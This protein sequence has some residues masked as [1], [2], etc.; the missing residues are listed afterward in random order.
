MIYLYSG[1]P[2]SGKSLH[3]AEVIFFKLRARHPVLANFDVN[4]Q[5][6][7]GRGRRKIAD[8]RYFSNED[9]SPGGLMDYSAAYF[10]NHRFREGQILLVIDE[11]QLLFNSRE[12]DAKGRAAWLSF[13]SQHRKY[14]YD[15]ILVA[16]FDR[17]LDRQIRSLIEYEYIHRKV[18][19][20]GVWGKIFSV[21]FLG[22]L[23]VSVK[24]WYPLRERIG[25]D[26]FVCK[27]KFFR[28]YDT[29]K[30]FGEDEQISP[31]PAR[32]PAKEKNE[33]NDRNKLLQDLV[34]VLE[35]FR[36]QKEAAEQHFLCNN[37]VAA[38]AGKKSSRFKDLLFRPISLFANN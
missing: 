18:S 34:T 27:P 14:G 20:F 8:F 30:H 29:Y 22:K 28:L 23:F 4:T 5:F 35:I 38:P 32:K 21:F 17:M 31:K 2:G 10:K 7:M 9:L 6:V 15:V 12:W 16:Q 24:M 1:T 33:E 26:W 36:Y 13:F 19:N 25:A 3:T 37:P 11:A